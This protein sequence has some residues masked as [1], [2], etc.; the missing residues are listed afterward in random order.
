MGMIWKRGTFH[1]TL[2]KLPQRLIVR[3]PLKVYIRLYIFG[4]RIQRRF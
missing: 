2:K 3:Y 4:F 1:D